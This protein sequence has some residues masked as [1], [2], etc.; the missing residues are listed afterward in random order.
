M[1][2]NNSA[3]PPLMRV[4]VIERVNDG[5]NLPPPAMSPPRKPQAKI[6]AFLAMARHPMSSPQSQHARPSAARHLTAKNAAAHN[7]NRQRDLPGLLAVWPSELSVSDNA[8]HARLL[9]R[10][11]RALRLER[12]R[13]LAGHWAYDLNRHA[14][15]LHAYR[16][17]VA[18]Y[19]SRNAKRAPG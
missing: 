19:R 17:E 10:M 1:S 5:D 16:V 13:G 9:A 4:Q 11:R 8:T 14:L 12:Q 6:A 7:Y 15:L 2:A 18:L 3:Q